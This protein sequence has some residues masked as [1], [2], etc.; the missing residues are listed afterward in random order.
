MAKNRAAQQLGKRGG[1]ANSP[2]QLTHRKTLHQRSPHSGRPRT[3]VWA[4][5][6]QF[7]GKDAGH[8]CYG[9]TRA[10]ARAKARARTTTSVIIRRETMTAEDVAALVAVGKL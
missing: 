8:V 5:I 2:A 10:E 7:N 4:A 9:R 1:L 6:A 3:H